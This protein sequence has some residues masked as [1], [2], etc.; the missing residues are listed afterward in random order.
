[1][2]G[3]LL[4]YEFM[5][6]QFIPASRRRGAGVRLASPKNGSKARTMPVEKPLAAKEASLREG[7]RKLGI[8]W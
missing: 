5:G 1:M 6:I 2:E 3:L 7:Y 4:A 8:V